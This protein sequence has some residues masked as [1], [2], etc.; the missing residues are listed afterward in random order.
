MKKSTQS[1]ILEPEKGLLCAKKLLENDFLSLD[2][3]ITRGPHAEIHS[4][5]RELFS[6]SRQ[7]IEL[8]PSEEEK[9]SYK[10]FFSFI[11]VG[12]RD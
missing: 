4:V 11:S 5:G 6:L 10:S 12:K 9:K 7:L 3:T 2:K 8:A 1:I